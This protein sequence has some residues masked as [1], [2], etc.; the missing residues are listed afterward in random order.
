MSKP[1]PARAAITHDKH[2]REYHRLTSCHAGDFVQVDGG[3]DCMS[4]NAHYYVQS[5]EHGHFIPCTHGRHYL[6][7]QCDH[8]NNDSLIGIYL[9]RAAD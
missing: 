6:D 9:V 3:F 4:A 1:A 8:G 5:D 7:G 2:G